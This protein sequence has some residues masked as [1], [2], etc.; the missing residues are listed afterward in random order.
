MTSKAEEARQEVQRL[1]RLL[2]DTG[3][4]IY[5]TAA[6]TALDALLEAGR[7]EGAEEMRERAAKATRPKTHSGMCKCTQC[8]TASRAARRIR[9]LPVKV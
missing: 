1:V 2:V 7:A 4:T 9:A 6:E 3:E 5:A 8:Q